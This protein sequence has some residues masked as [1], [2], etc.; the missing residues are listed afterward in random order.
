MNVDE[1]MSDKD[2]EMGK[3]LKRSRPN[4]IGQDVHLG[5]DGITIT[6]DEDKI[7]AIQR[8]YKHNYY[9]PGG[10]GYLATAGSWSSNNCPR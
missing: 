7:I 5:L 2:T 4:P 9:K 8:I 3:T 1:F 10:K 6:R